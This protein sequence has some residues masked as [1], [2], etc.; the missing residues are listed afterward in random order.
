MNTYESILYVSVNWLFEAEVSFKLK[1][2]TLA[3]GAPG[4]GTPGWAL[5]LG[6]VEPKN[7]V[8]IIEDTIFINLKWKNAT[9]QY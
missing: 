7:V 3:G 9:G 5:H 8:Q 1:W 2:I 6:G 4:G